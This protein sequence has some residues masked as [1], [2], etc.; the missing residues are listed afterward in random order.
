P[1][2]IVKSE[3]EYLA[4][5]SEKEK[6]LA[7]VFEEILQVEQIGIDDNFFELGGHSLR[8]LKLVNKISDITNS[9]ISIKD[10]FDRPTVRL[11]SEK[12][13]QNTKN[14]GIE[15]AEHKDFYEMSSVQKRMY[16]LYEIDKQATTYNMPAVIEV[17]GEIDVE[18]IQRTLNNLIDRHEALRTS[19]YIFENKHIQKIHNNVV[20]KIEILEFEDDYDIEKIAIDFIKP[21]TLE[22][23]PLI[24]LYIIKTL[25][26]NYIMFDMHHIISDGMSMG[27]VISEFT[28]IYNGEK[29]EK[30]SLQYKDYSEWNKGRD[31]SIQR[32]YWKSELQSLPTLDIP[33]DYVRPNIQS[34]RGS[35]VHATID[36][37]VFDKIKSEDRTVTDYMALLS[38]FMLVLSKYSCQQDVVLGTPV[39]GRTTQQT[40]NML[41]MFVNTLVMRGRPENDKTFEEFL[42]EVKE[43]SILAFDNQEYPFEELMEI[44]NVTRDISRNPVFDVMFVLQNNEMI[45]IE[46]ENINMKSVK[47]KNKTSKFDLLLTAIKVDDIYSLELEYCTDLFTEETVNR[48]LNKLVNFISNIGKNLDKKIKDISLLSEYEKKNILENFATGEEV[49]IEDRTIVEIFEDIVH[50]RYDKTALVFEDQRLTYSEFNERVNELAHTLRSNGI[51]NNDVVALFIDRSIEMLVAMF[52]AMK[53]GG[54]YLPITTDTP[55]DRVEY[56]LKDSKAKILL[57]DQSVNISSNIKVLDVKNNENYKGN[58]QNLVRVNKATDLCYIIYTSGTT[59]N[60]KGVEVEHKGVSN[61]RETII[62]NVKVSK[63]ERTLQF[64]SYSFDASVWEVIQSLLIGGELHIIS[65][66]NV[67]DA[68]FIKD[69]INNNITAVMLPPAFANQLKLDGLN[70]LLTAGSE[71]INTVVDNCTNINQI[72]NAYGPTETTVVVTLYKVCEITEGKKVPIGRPVINSQVY[73]L[74]DKLLC[75][76]GM[77]GEVVIGGK[78]VTRGY[79]N[80]DKLTNSKYIDNIFGEGKLYRSGDLARWLPDG[81]IQYLGRI[82]GQVKI[83]GFRIELLDIENNIRSMESIEDVAIIAKEIKGENTILA[84]VASND[85]VSSR[86]IRD[87]LRKKLPEYMLPQYI[88]EVESIPVNKN[89][90][91]DKKALPEVELDIES[92]YVSPTN[93]IEKVIC[94]IYQDILS[95]KK[96]GID[97]NFFEIGGHSLRATKLTNQILEKTGNKLPLKDIFESPTPKELAL[98]VNKINRYTMIEKSREKEYYTMSSA[99]KR[100]YFTNEIIGSNTSQNIPFAVEIFG[101]VDIENIQIAFNKLIDRHESLRTEFLTYENEPIQKV[102]KEILAT[103]TH[104]KY[105]EEIDFMETISRFVQPFE[106]DKAPLIRMEF[107]ETPNHKYILVDMHHIISDGMSMGIICEDFIKIYNNIKLE[108]CKYQYKD[109]SEWLSKQD[110][111]NQK[112]YWIN[113]FSDNIPV[114]ELPY[115]FERSKIT[116]IAGA[117][118]KIIFG[119]DILDKINILAQ[120]TKTTDYMIFLSVINIMLRKYSGQEDIVVGSP[121][122]GRTLKEV[123]KIVGMFVNTLP[124][125]TYPSDQKIYLD[126]LEEVKE[127]CLNAFENQEYPF[128]EIISELNVVRDMSRNPIFDVMFAMQNNEQI[129]IS[130]NDISFKS[131]EFETNTTKF[132]LVMN[133]SKLENNYEVKLDYCTDLFSEQ[134]A[135]RF[136]KSFKEILSSILENPKNKICDIYHCDSESEK[137]IEGFNETFKEYNNNRT[138]VEIFEDTVKKHPDNIAVE[139]KDESI[140]YRELN[141]RSNALGEEL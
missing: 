114:L 15:K 57:T 118:R 124:I 78:G 29:L 63:D 79:R 110:L 47:F 138:L 76:I 99:Q 87:H 10:V 119:K 103:V 93:Y 23:P 133:A 6:I 82:D 1:E 77:I 53:A 71:F 97:D 74:Q 21:F 123:E 141:E 106:L 68:M 115:D 101:E 36:A 38:S 28:K 55:I 69:Y 91:L 49:V 92:N 65:K 18:R 139:H 96:V 121:I 137:A 94:E 100:M 111:E 59:G 61:L 62:R 86:D 84:Y 122:S 37:N 113:Q 105:K 8:A 58:V 64:A 46:V 54:C 134:S 70:I 75:D 88:I 26:R 83:R 128:E 112:Q 48:I 41:G 56:I 90:K 35:S 3:K 44:L 16:T 24:R 25:K 109:Y 89:G 33:I 39:S 60:P 43:T 135:E 40:Q 52:S 7:S 5:R 19:F 102:I 67:K 104:S 42:K 20:S 81:N 17:V 12:A 31:Y 51:S 120:T 132:D 14:I 85:M 129:D 140:T 2:I 80:L 73:I 136:L 9:D 117:T 95:L 22:K 11:L 107:V 66:D 98:K 34:H 116:S 32:D 13:S 126:Y 108:E 72:L 127:I 50:E 131:I 130:I 4:P 125:R 45:D 30:L 27:I